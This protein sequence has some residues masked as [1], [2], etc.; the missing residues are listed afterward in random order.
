MHTQ[1]VKYAE[2][3]CLPSKELVPRG[4]THAPN[5][6]LVAVYCYRDIYVL[7][8][9]LYYTSILNVLIAGCVLYFHA[10]YSVDLTVGLRMEG[11][12]IPQVVRDCVHAVEQSGTTYV[13]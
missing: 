13:H 10:V 1:C 9:L 11:T 4:K 7:T 3:D 6:G 2:A 5:E 8:G 12:K